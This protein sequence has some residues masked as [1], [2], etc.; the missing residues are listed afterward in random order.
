[1]MASISSNMFVNGLPSTSCLQDNIYA[2]YP[3][4]LFHLFIDYTV[5]S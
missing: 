2:L 1:M 4:V 3:D 5:F